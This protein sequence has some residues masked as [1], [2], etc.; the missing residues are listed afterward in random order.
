MAVAVKAN[1]SS[2]EVGGAR[3]LFKIRTSPFWTHFA[4]DVAPDGQ[5]FL[6]DAAVGDPAPPSVDIVLNWPAALKN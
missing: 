4:Y 5:R 2:F 6:I 3:A 1:A